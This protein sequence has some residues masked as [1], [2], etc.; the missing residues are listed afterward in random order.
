MKKWSQWAIPALAGALL[1]G[2]GGVASVHAQDAANPFIGKWKV[3]WQGEKR[4][5]E[6]DLEITASGGQ[7]Q[8]MASRKGDPCVGRAA[9]VEITSASAEKLEFIIKFS[10]ALQGCKDS[11]TLSLAREADGKVS[12]MRGENPL[13]LTRK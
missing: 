9:P 10:T 5:Q 6:A 3:E 7:W 13:T 2:V 1:M 4:S 12:G 11:S 8:T